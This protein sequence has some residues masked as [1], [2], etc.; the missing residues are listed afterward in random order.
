MHY[1]YLNPDLRAAT[2]ASYR[3]IQ[4]DS[5]K[6][7]LIISK[8]PRNINITPLNSGFLLKIGPY[9]FAVETQEKMLEKISNYLKNPIETEETWGK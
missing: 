2:P 1:T 7:E 3:N 5:I 9:S 8:I 4:N 6:K